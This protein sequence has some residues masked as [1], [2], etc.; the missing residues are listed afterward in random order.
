MKTSDNGISLIHKYEQFRNHPYIC[1]AGKPTIGWGNTYY[2]D[3]SK[4]TMQDPPI[5][6]KR[7]DELFNYILRKTENEVKKYVTSDINQNQFSALVSFTYNVGI[8]NF[9]ISTLLKKVNNNQNDFEAIEYEFKRWNKGTVK[10]KKVV[11]KGL[12]KRR[13]EEA[14]LYVL[15]IE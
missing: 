10:G 15:P 12:I 7:G 13:N 5:T 11:L 14:Y 4:V 1:P 3:G 9:K 6:R 8:D 2:E